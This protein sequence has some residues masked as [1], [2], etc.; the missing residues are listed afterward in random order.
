MNAVLKPKGVAESYTVKAVRAC[1]EGIFLPI[2]IMSAENL[3]QCQQHADRLQAEFDADCEPV[4]VYVYLG[5]VPVYAGL[6]CLNKY[7][8]PRR[9][10]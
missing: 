5:E 4:R 8:R 10:Q 6:Q 1:T 3:G 2:E 7:G 9:V